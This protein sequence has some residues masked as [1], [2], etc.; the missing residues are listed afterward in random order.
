MKKMAKWFLGSCIAASILA[1]C[2]F[3]L[4]SSKECVEMETTTLKRLEDVSRDAWDR[5]AQKKILFGHHSVGDNILEGIRAIC[6]EHEQVHLEIVEAKSPYEVIDPALLHCR[7]GKN[8][9]PRSKAEEFRDILD[10]GLGDKIDIAFFKFCYVDMGRSSNPDSIF[11]HYRDVLHDLERRFPRV[12]FL[13]VTVPLTAPEPGLKQR[14]RRMKNKLLGQPI[15][16]DDNRVREAYNRKLREEYGKGEG[17]ALF[18]LARFESI[19]PDD[20]RRFY[21]YR[22]E[23]IPSLVGSYTEDGGHL[24]ATGQRRIAE[25]LLVKLSEMAS[26]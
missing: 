11:A 19:G 1:A 22:D 17:A 14:L 16:L 26:D 18:D 25:Q 4:L 23:E 6:K 20:F 9:D 10:S 13:H 8:G 3:W 12:R 7:V 21:S 2:C 5:L 24:N 15:W